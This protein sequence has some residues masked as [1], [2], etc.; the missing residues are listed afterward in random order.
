MNDFWQILRAT[1]VP[2]PSLE[3]L[4]LLAVMAVA[5]VFRAARLGLF[6]AYLFVFRWGYLFFE[7]TFP[8]DQQ[9]YVIGYVIFGGVTLLLSI[10]SLLLKEPSS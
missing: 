1:E 8:G 10:I 9:G 2:I 3:L 5:L 7:Q 4:L 6:G